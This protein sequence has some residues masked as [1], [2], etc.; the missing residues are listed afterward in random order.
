MSHSATPAT[1]NEATPRLKPP[2]VT[3][4]VALSKGTARRPSRRHLRTVADGCERLRTVADAN[5]RSSEHT[6]NPQTPRVKREPLLRV[7]KKA[8]GPDFKHSKLTWIHNSMLVM[9][10]FA[11][12]IRFTRFTPE[13]RCWSSA[14]QCSPWW[15][16]SYHVPPLLVS[17][18]ESRWN[19]QHRSDWHHDLAMAEDPMEFHG[20]GAERCWKSD[21]WRI[22]KIG[23]TWWLKK[24]EHD[25]SVRGSWMWI[26]NHVNFID[27]NL[28]ASLISCE[29]N[30]LD[31]LG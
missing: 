29:T 5:A 31:I 12:D 15:V 28:S 4:F 2:Q 11:S 18:P 25:K 9:I 21:S 23:T 19:S 20:R 3:T 13:S 22:G 24:D 30:A 10:H 14:N 6:L 8:R 16:S 26:C 7:R 17:W 27:V 1:R